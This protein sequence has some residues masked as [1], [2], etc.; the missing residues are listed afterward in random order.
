MDICE[1]AIGACLRHVTVTAVRTWVVVAFLKQSTET[2]MVYPQIGA[3]GV[4]KPLPND[5]NPQMCDSSVLE[6]DYRNSDSVSA[7]WR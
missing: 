7:N 6:A 1:S 5:S 3:G 4:L 2:D